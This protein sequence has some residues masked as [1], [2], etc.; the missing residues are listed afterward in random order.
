MIK[1]ADSINDEK[2]FEEE[3]CNR[4]RG[5]KLSGVGTKMAKIFRTAFRRESNN[6]LR[7]QLQSE[8][9]LESNENDD[10]VTRNIDKRKK[11]ID[12]TQDLSSSNW[13]SE[14]N[15]SRSR[16]NLVQ[17][18][19][20]SID[21]IHKSEDLNRD[22]KIKISRTRKIKQLRRSEHVESNELE[23][24][25][26][27]VTVDIHHENINSKLSKN[28]EETI[29]NI[30]SDDPEF[31][32]QIS[33]INNPE[34]SL[35]TSLDNSIDSMNKKQR[36]RWSK[37]TN[38]I[39]PPKRNSLS[40]AS[41]S[42]KSSNWMVADATPRPVPA[43]RIKKIINNKVKNNLGLDNEAFETDHDEMDQILTIETEY[44][45]DEQTKIKI[46]PV[47]SESD[48][49]FDK[50]ILD[51]DTEKSSDYSSGIPDIEAITEIQRL[52]MD[53][54]ITN[55]EI[56]SE[57]EFEMANRKKSDDVTSVRRK[58][59]SK[60][61]SKSMTDNSSSSIS[62]IQ[63]PKQVIDKRH[64]RKE[65][66]K[67]NIEESKRSTSLGHDDSGTS[68]TSRITQ[69]SSRSTT[70]K[71]KGKKMM[72]KKTTIKYISIM[73][74]RT[75]TLI[76]DY[77]IRHPMVI[78]HIVEESTGNYLKNINKTKPNE[79]YLQPL[80]TGI[81]DIKVNKSMAP[82]WDE[83]LIFEY[84]FNAILNTKENQILI[85][86]EI[87]DLPSVTDASSTHDQFGMMNNFI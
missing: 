87:V 73:V 50:Q 40:S 2:E 33:V 16:T 48:R 7:Q 76:P 85:L 67:K 13:S 44:G 23:T 32:Q 46:S 1:K 21:Y 65:L 9:V 58:K 71:K 69:K 35:N 18:R 25:S 27:N 28:I 55:S 4:R 14:V 66:M 45:S 75:D 51:K 36:K 78:V 24:T 37:E 86:F 52:S 19:K 82:Y 26:M 30:S 72:N 74:H 83:E 20:K 31:E 80:I 62:D 79:T 11:I 63:R 68:E 10:E 5:G 84:D 61:Q 6:Q 59:V 81:F 70:K 38:I 22:D 49:F 15:V 53:N 57:M 77:I 17:E 60:K 64:K 41:V 43:P 42:E 34:K 39:L 29:V 3:N 54:T 12:K 47:K 8:M 56:N